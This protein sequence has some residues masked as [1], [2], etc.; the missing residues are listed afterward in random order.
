MA[1]LQ[2]YLRSKV[3]VI[4]PNEFVARLLKTLLNNYGFTLITVFSSMEAFAKRADDKAFGVIICKKDLPSSSGLR[5][6]K[7]IRSGKTPVRYDIP[8]I[9]FLENAEPKLVFEARDTGVNEICVEPITA[10]NLYKK[11]KLCFEQPRAFI[12][13]SGY[14]GPDRRRKQD[15]N[16]QGPERRGTSVAA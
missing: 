5:L 14:I 12:T 11:L 16:Y 9:L 8:F 3:A 13:D 6:L 15:P 7:L 1:G 4:E 10:A 2:A